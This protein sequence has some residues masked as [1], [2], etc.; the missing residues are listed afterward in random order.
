MKSETPRLINQTEV[1]YFLYRVKKNFPNFVAGVITDR[2]GFPIGSQISKRL[3]VHENTLALWAISKNKE[4]VIREPNL[5]Q[6]K[7]NIDKYKRYKL[8]LLVE[9]SKNHKAKLKIL[10]H[11]LKSQK[12]F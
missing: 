5:V 1:N 11:M 3:W 6:L 7:F 2:N 9:K 8:Y 4:L 10:K 12:L